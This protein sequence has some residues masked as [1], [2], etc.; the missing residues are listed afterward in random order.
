[1]QK[2]KLLISLVIFILSLS[3][4]AEKSPIPILNH[5]KI[6]AHFE[7]YCYK[8]HDEDVQK[9]DIRLDKLPTHIRTQN[10]AQS[11]QDVLDVLNLGE[12]PP[13]K[14]KKHPSQKETEDLLETLS[15]SMKHV[16]L[17]LSDSGTETVVRRLNRREYVVTI[18]DL[19]G[20]HI[21]INNLPEDNLVDGF[22][23]VG[24]ALSFSSLHFNKYYE[25]GYSIISDAVQLGE[26]ALSINERYEGEKRKTPYVK[27]AYR[28]HKGKLEGL[29]K[30]KFKKTVEEL[31]EAQLKEIGAHKTLYPLARDYL[32]LEAS[33][34]GFLSP[35]VGHPK[36]KVFYITLPVVKQ[37]GDY[38][39]KIRTGM[40]LHDKMQ[41]QKNKEPHAVL[42][43]TFTKANHGEPE[44]DT[45][46][47]VLT[48]TY[49]KP[50]D[51]ELR[52]RLHKNEQYKLAFRGGSKRIHNPLVWIDWVDFKGPL[53]EEW[54]PKPYKTIFAEGIKENRSDEEVRTII[55]NFA[56]KAFRGK[57]PK[58]EF[59]DK[60]FGV[61]KANIN[62]GKNFN[63]SIAESLAVILASPM[64]IYKLEDASGKNISDTELASRLSYFLWNSMP[65]KYLEGLAK[66]NEL[67]K[68][69]VLEQ[70][71]YRMLDD[72]KSERFIKSFVEQ[73]F[74][75]DKF[76]SAQIFTKTAV[77]SHELKHSARQE[78]IEFFKYLLKNN[79]SAKN[80]IK[81]DFLI[82]N[83]ILSENYGI[84]GIKGS[85]FQYVKLSNKSPYGG[86]LTQA[87]TMM[88]TSHGAKT[89]PVERGAFVLRK[90]LD[91][92]PN[93]PPPNVPSIKDEDLKNK[94]PREVLKIHTSS[95]QCNSCHRKIDPIGLGLENYDSF[96]RWR[97]KW[98]VSK[99]LSIKIDASGNMHDGSGSFKGA[100]ELKEH[101]SRYTAETLRGVVKSMIVYALGRNVSFSDQPWI[102]RL[103]TNSSKNDFKMKDLLVDFVTSPEFRKK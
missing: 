60:V 62:S 68:N 76:D 22:D 75:L 91:A 92:A 52:V 35:Q 87:A 36:S 67:H 16:R 103:I 65:D 6:K 86:L 102:D 38:L 98:N 82:I 70:Q 19:L 50:R 39:V 48:N 5:E 28:D 33:K 47:Y 21:N 9:G 59:I 54:P 77:Y 78:P 32:N 20:M 94:S 25:K 99:K 27:K 53:K 43:F 71:I 93:P 49:D 85:E 90:F 31:T 88:M 44:V 15:N 55:S 3:T 4:Y 74:S 12:M 7:V 29:A 45:Y 72:E 14:S 1:M 96:A 41:T 26:K 80:L 58:S 13:E 40:V 57:K 8:C 10:Q 56:L 83:Y 81:S 24:E 61:Y 18:K 2:K 79:M 46:S 95:P 17:K 51:I 97:E 11:W 63:D 34:T 100:F 84:E 37:E 64:F 89:S 30:S 23:T 73:W 101:L 69:D 66:V 42:N